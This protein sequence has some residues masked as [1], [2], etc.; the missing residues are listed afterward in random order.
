MRAFDS[1]YAAA[2]EAA[3]SRLYGGI[4]YRMA[5]EHGIEQGS[6]VG[7]NVL[8]TLSLSEDAMALNE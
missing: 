5:A 7:K 8:I 4:H 1:F 3:I 6:N 2:D